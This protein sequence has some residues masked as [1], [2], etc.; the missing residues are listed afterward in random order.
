MRK[1][2]C[3]AILFLSILSACKKESHTPAPITCASVSADSIGVGGAITFMS[4]TKGDTSVVWSF[5][6]STSSR[7]DT[8]THYY[9][10]PGTYNATLSSFNASGKGLVKNFAIV[11]TATD[12]WTVKGN[13]YYSSQLW[14]GTN[15]YNSNYN[16]LLG[17][18]ANSA[19][20]VANSY[21]NINV[22]FTGCGPGISSI[23]DTVLFGSSPTPLNGAQISIN[24]GGLSYVSIPNNQ[25][26]SAIVGANGK[27]SVSGTNIKVASLPT[28]AD[29]E[30]VSFHLTQ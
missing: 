5:G 15:G 23:T 27:V 9:Y 28:L 3:I 25:I 26:I 11:V 13:T 2:L 30:T 12:S 6:D 1:N 22:G 24:Y 8:I 18:Q 16:Y 7:A 19:L 17:F 14:V 29:T 21:S 10:L 20:Y 4:C